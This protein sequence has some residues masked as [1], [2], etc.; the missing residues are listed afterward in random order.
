MSHLNS[1]RFDNLN[2]NNIRGAIPVGI[3][4]LTWLDSL[5]LSSNEL[6]GQIPELPRRLRKLD[7]SMNFLSGNLPSNCG[8]PYIKDLIMSYNHIAG[9]VPE[10]VCKLQ[11]LYILDLTII[12]LRENFPSVLGCQ[13]YFSYS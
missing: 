6:T 9:H 5:F 8:S 11:N 3:Q 13:T 2:N 12:L 10:S 4:N 7:V 1:I